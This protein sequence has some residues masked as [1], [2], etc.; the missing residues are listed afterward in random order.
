[1]NIH[2]YLERY[3]KSIMRARDLNKVELV[4]QKAM[5]LL[6][7]TG[8]EGFTMNKLAKEC[9]ISVATLYIYYKDKDDLILQI[10]MEEAERMSK[11]MLE[12]FDPEV[13]FEVGL[14]QQ[15]KNRAKCM[16]ENPITAQFLEQLRTSTYQEQVYGTIVNNFKITLGKFMTNAINRGEI[17]PMQLEV[18]W[19]V[20]FAPLYNLVRFHFEGRSIGGKPFILT[21]KALWETF[22]LVIKALKK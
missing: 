11:V 7:K 9:K 17:N 2:L 6:V 16:L 10:A 21:D 20:A 3:L 19:S 18:Y 1:M 15:W 22:E 8:F 4:K 13:S 14:R 5:E 12:N